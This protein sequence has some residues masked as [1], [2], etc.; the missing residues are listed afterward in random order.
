MV[1]VIGVR[2]QESGKIYYFA[3]AGY[4]S[5]CVGEYVVVETS[6]GLELARVVIAPEQVLN[7]ELTEPLKPI[8]RLATAADLAQA[9]RLKERAAQDVEAAKKKAHQLNLSMKIAAGSYNLDGNRLTLLFT[10]DGRIDFRDLVRELAAALGAQVLLRQVGPRDQAK[11]VGGYGRCGR[12][13][14]CSS[15]L[16]NFPAISIKMA[17]EQDLPLNPSKISGQCG[18]LLCCLSY[19]NETYREIKHALPRP[20]TYLS[21]PNGNARVQAVNVPREQ[22]TLAM[23]NGPT[24]DVPLRELGLDQGLVRILPGPPE[25]PP[26]P[27]AVTPVRDPL[28]RRAPPLAPVAPPRRTTPVPI[29]NGRPHRPMP[30]APLA[31]EPEKQAEPGAEHRTPRRRR[32]P[33]RSGV[34]SGNSRN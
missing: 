14:C 12:R 29:T 25:P 4:D 18:R 31:T 7:A 9:Q 16:V 1:G 2:F 28:P 5:V 24:I 27:A 10:S 3:A 21:T 26:A 23:E 15:W 20:G 33:R 17:K 8:T 32:R 30:P 19:E 22:V 34:D 11:A 6:R 13:L